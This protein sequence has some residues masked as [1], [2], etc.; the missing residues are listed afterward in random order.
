MTFI[1]Y[2]SLTNHH[3]ARKQRFIKF[4]DEYVATEKFTVQ[5][6]QLLLTTKTTL[7]LL[8]VQLYLLNKNVSNALG[9]L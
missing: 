4:D 5:M 1:K 9:I 3:V 8:N 6:Y 7:K 2:P